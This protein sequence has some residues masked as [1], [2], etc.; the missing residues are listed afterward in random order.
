MARAQAAVRFSSNGRPYLR[1]AEI[2]GT[3]FCDV[4]NPT[5]LG[6]PLDGWYTPE[7]LLA[8]LK[9]DEVGRIAS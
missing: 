9:R 1:Q 6:H 2:C 7:G 8:L 4:R 5:R 3:W